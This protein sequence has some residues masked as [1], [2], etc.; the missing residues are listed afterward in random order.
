MIKSYDTL[1]YYVLLRSLTFNKQQF[2]HIKI[3]KNV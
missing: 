1:W 2:I 3:Y